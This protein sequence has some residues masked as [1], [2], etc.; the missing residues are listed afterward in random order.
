MHHTLRTARGKVVIKVGQKTDTSDASYAFGSFCLDTRAGELRRNDERV[1][2]TPKVFQLLLILL[3]NP[4]R[5]IAKRELLDKIWGDTN[6]EEGS[7]TRAVTRLRSALTDN[8]S[9]PQY[10]QTVPR[11]GYR[12]LAAVQKVP[13]GDIAR[14]SRFEVVEGG[15]RHALIEGDNVLGRA[16]DCEV[17]LPLAS[18]SRH[19]AVI[20]VDGN[21]ITVQDL[22]SKN[23]TFIRGRRVDGVVDIG[24]GDQIRL[25]SVTV[26][27]ASE[28][29]DLSTLTETAQKK[30]SGDWE[31]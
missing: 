21:R 25:G 16:E 12:F 3:Q 19:H 6:V 26:I 30:L 31:K 22:H 18:I 17:S 10:V 5:L 9:R 20:T 27:L 15:R 14:Q 8:A 24:D 2:L 11:R 7:V 4:G 28:S 1:P 13:A 23:G 29:A